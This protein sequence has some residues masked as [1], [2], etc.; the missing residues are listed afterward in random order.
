MAT[1]ERP[2]WWGELSDDER[3][4]FETSEELLADAVEVARQKAAGIKRLRDRARQR[5]KLKSRGN[6]NAGTDRQGTAEA[7][8]DRDQACPVP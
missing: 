6:R 3:F 2:A 1:T 8:R 5:L 4:E 7:L